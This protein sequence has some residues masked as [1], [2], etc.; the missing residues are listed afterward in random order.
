MTL[1]FQKKKIYEL[2]LFFFVLGLVS[3]ATIPLKI[4]LAA[5]PS[6]V[7]NVV[8]VPAS[9]QVTL[10]WSNPASVDFTGTM[11][12]YSTSAFPTSTSDGTLASDVAGAVSGTST[13]TVTG[14]TNGTIYYFSLF[15]HN[16]TPE[17]SAAVNAQQLVMAS[18]FSDDFESLTTG[19]VAGQNGWA[20]VAGTWTILDT[21]GEQTLKSSTENLTFDQ[22]RV[23][24]GGNVNTYSN[25]MVRADWRGT[26]TNA[27][28]QLFLRTQSA[29]ADAGGYSLTT[30][31]GLL[32]ISYKS[33]TG[34]SFTSLGTGSF[35]PVANTWYVYEFSVVNNSAGLPVLSAYVWA[36]GSAK[37]S[38][39][40]VTA[41][42]TAN[43]FAQG[44]FS[45]GKSATTAAEY[46]N[47]SFYGMMGDSSAKVIP[48]DGTN[49]ISWT[50]PSTA[51]YSGTMVRVS[52]SAYPATPSDGT[53]VADV[54]G[55]SGATSSTTNSGLT[56]GTLY[57]Y[58]LFPHDSSNVYGTPLSMSQVPYPELVSENFNSLSL[59]T[60]AGQNGWGIE[61]GTWTVADVLSE[62]VLTSTESE[63]YLTN[64]AVNNTSSTFNQ[65]V[66]YRFKSNAASNGAGYVWLRRQSNND[67]YL[68]WHN[69]NAWTIATQVGATFTNRAAAATTTISPLEA[70]VWFNVEASV[71]NNGSNH[72]V[73]NVFSWKEGKEKPL[74][75]TITYTDSSDLFTSGNFALG[76]NISS[77][78]STF[79]D[80]RFAASSA[81]ASASP[82]MTITSPAA[83]V[84]GEPDT[85]TLA[86]TDEA[87][88]FYIPYIQTSTTLNVAATLDNIPSGGGIR[89]ILNEGLA[90]AQTV[91]DLS[92][93]TYTA[94]FTGL[95]KAEYTLDA[96][97]IL[98]DGVTLSS[99]ALMHDH[100]DHIGIG[101]IISIIGDSTSDGSGGTAPDNDVLSW[102]D[103]A[104]GSLSQDHRNF[105]QD[106]LGLYK[107]SYL[108]DLNDK[109]T[110]YFGHPV[111]LMNEGYIG[112][113]S[114]NYESTVMISNW[115]FRELALAPS[116]WIVALG[117]GDSQISHSAATYRADM[118]ILLSRLTTTYGASLSNIYVPY[119][120]YDSRD[121]IV[122]YLVTYPAEIDDMRSDLGLA[123]GPDLY[124]TFINY[125]PAEYNGVHP[126]STG[127]EHIARLWA[128]A[129]MQPTV[130]SA[131]SGRQVTLN[132]NDLG[133]AEST[134]SG[135]QIAY[136]TT[137][138][139]LNNTVTVG[140]VT[141]TTLDNLLW[142]TTYYYTVRGFDNDPYVV[143]YT[144]TSG[145]GTV[146]TGTGSSTLVFSTITGN[147]IEGGGTA[148]FDVSLSNQPGASV[149]VPISSSDTTEGTV[150]PSSLTF[151]SA[152]WNTPQTVTV[153]GIDD[154]EVDGNV[155]YSI[156]FGAIT[157]SDVT[158]TG[159]NP[160]DVSV[161]NTDDESSTTA[162]TSSNSSGS[163][164]GSSPGI[165]H[166]Q[167]HAIDTGSASEEDSTDAGVESGS[168]PFPDVSTDSENTAVSLLVE[169]GV[170]KGNPDGTFKPR[171]NLNRAE[172]AAMLWRLLGIT[173]VSVD[174][175][176][177]PDVLKSVWYA[178][179][180][181]GLKDLNFV[182]GNPDGNFLPAQEV[183]R[184]VFF[185]L[186]MD[187]FLYLNPDFQE[188][189]NAILA[190]GSGDKYA[191]LSNDDWYVDS[192]KAA[193]EFGFAELQSCGDS[194]CFN[195]QSLLTRG[196]AS[197]ILYMMFK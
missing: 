189:Y 149:T 193:I 83:A 3:F 111:F 36:R 170:L 42:D 22:Y 118:E 4:T 75:P 115:T 20:V 79:D 50:N 120:F 52:T 136:G 100:R 53:L 122:E 190:T 73:I 139:N 21:S 160:D 43:R 18:S 62:R 108:S 5:A 153:R 47:V 194:S 51:T 184:A 70:D 106:G 7:T 138:S 116:M 162:S 99:N 30:S 72:P 69:G 156:V 147:T 105:P 39:P 64:M 175:D 164:G 183:N 86:I 46:D 74:T 146:A 157:S 8:P 195:P 89:F 80:V 76:R 180:V 124:N 25:Q 78:D 84:A 179:Y 174:E 98:G 150:S 145:T 188:R 192:A 66:S 2:V 177:F 56:N 163:S 13:L 186:A 167:D 54:S 110:T 63:T 28:G 65:V 91:N 171:N 85:A 38:T 44:V 24:N 123:G 92:G 181:A 71:I 185:K 81:A 26:T 101:D 152:N 176:V 37:P 67:G 96:Y 117:N 135:Y 125:K 141:S 166:S 154:F 172:F 35:T 88:T 187:L 197:E 140:D 40:T 191:D 165:D 107:E 29:S 1:G 178:T 169:R 27:P 19:D 112:I 133:A 93:P 45:V 131:V 58:T 103:A 57:Y 60:I 23:L 134:V 148:T 142:D 137:S 161:T 155:A 143:S 104:A 196:K 77:A 130:T 12:R 49:T 182:N 109:L 168:T 119:P 16:S 94:S 90:G 87:G 34:T 158:F 61:G 127:Y 126:D 173:D 17:Y 48:G 41:T 113:K 95:A 82:N 128:L 151:T 97:E 11:V 10:T 33:T 132:W 6:V 114:S 32:R 129:I 68:I 121:G 59:D 14:L 9:G 15:S 144:D 159:V 55:S 31:G 102:L